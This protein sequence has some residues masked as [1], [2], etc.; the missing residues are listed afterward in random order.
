[1]FEATD[2]FVYNT[3]HFISGHTLKHFT[4]ALGPLFFLMVLCKQ[5]GFDKRRSKIK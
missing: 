1:L 4:A 5:R 3:N 2:E